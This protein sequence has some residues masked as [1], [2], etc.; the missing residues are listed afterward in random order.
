M[1]IIIWEYIVAEDR[2]AEFL[3][4]YG[5][6]GDWAQLFGQ[7]MGYLGTELYRD[8]TQPRRYITIDRWNSS[9]DFDSFQEN[10]RLAYEAMDERCKSLTEQEARIGTGDL[11]SST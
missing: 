1:F 2:E 4:I 7:G 8:P 10:Y 9:S 5:A 3:K 11:I 6:N